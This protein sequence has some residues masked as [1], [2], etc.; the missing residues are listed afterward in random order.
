MYVKNSQLMSADNLREEIAA[1]VERYHLQRIVTSYVPATDTKS[2]KI[3]AINTMGEKGEEVLV[4]IGEDMD[5]QDH[6]DLAA[7]MMAEKLDWIPKYF[8]L[9][10]ITNWGDPDTSELPLSGF[11]YLL[12]E[13]GRLQ[14]NGT[15]N[16]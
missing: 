6:H 4:E 1:N 5:L 7:L 16:S 13:R 14:S 9:R 2:A 10:A 12:I 11:I 15:D 3:K 8:L